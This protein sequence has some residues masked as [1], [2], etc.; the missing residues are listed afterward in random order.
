[1]AMGPV[2][3][4]RWYVMQTSFQ[5]ERTGLFSH[6]LGGNFNYA[7]QVFLF[8]AFLLSLVVSLPDY[9]QQNLLTGSVYG[10]LFLGVLVLV[11]FQLVGYFQQGLVLALV[12]FCTVEIGQGVLDHYSLKQTDQQ[13]EGCCHYVQCI[14]LHNSHVLSLLQHYLIFQCPLH[15]PTWQFF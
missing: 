14:H 12:N 6:F 9:A 3:L 10:C 8:V 2:L 4:S 13:N 11:A 7:I 1:M 15:L 5:Q